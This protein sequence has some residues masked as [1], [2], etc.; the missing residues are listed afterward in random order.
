MRL[1]ESER[2]TPSQGQLDAAEETAL[3]RRVQGGDLD[4]FAPLVEQHLP[5]LRAF[6]ALKTPTVHLVDELAHETFVYAFRH[7]GEFEAGTSLAKWLRAIAWNLLRAELKRA[8]R[9]QA[10]HTRYALDFR[11]EE[12][13]TEDEAAESREV[14]FLEE[15]LGELPETLRDLVMIKYR[16]DRSGEEIARR[17]KRSTAWVWTSLFRVRRQLRDCIQRKQQATPSC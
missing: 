8:G 7:M 3:V 2:M 15:C 4:A 17:L 10:R 9:E 13:G 11:F 5:H 14:G 6:I 1:Y 16:E 12:V